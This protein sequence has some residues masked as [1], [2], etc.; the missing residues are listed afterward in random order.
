MQ[1]LFKRL[2]AISLG[3]IG[4]SVFA[5]ENEKIPLAIDSIETQ[6]VDEHLLRLV[7]YNTE[8]EPKITIQLIETPV[9]KLAQQRIIDKMKLNGNVYDF[10]Q[11]GDIDIQQT[12]IKHGV[13]SI[14]MEFLPHKGTASFVARCQVNANHNRLSEIQCVKTKTEYE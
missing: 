5:G 13:V 8:L 9:L 1:T 2:F 4:V 6:R 7:V 11:D 14:Q 10:K 12:A 3:F